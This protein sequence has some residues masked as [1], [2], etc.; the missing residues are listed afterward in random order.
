VEGRAEYGEMVATFAALAADFGE[1]LSDATCRDLERLAASVECIDRRID[2][3]KDDDA[4]KSAWNDV[5]SVLDGGASSRDDELGR[6]AIDLRELASTRNACARV[7]RIMR[8]E[9]RVAETMRHT[10]HAGT[11]VRCTL[12]EGRLGAALTLAVAGSSPRFRRFFFRLGGPANVIDKIVDVRGDHASGEVRMRP[13]LRVYARLLH[14]L[15]TTVP[16]A[17]AAH[18]RWPRVVLLGLRWGVKLASK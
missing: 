10:E 3:E 15:L 18:P 16:A 5:L 4:R 12:R 7:A 9:A 6:A 11:Y 17:L 14:A 8:K 13:S 1:Q 2:D